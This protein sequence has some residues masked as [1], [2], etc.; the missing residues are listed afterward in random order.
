MFLSR[1]RWIRGFTLIELMVVTAIIAIL[2]AILVPAIQRAQTRA[3]AINC[4]AKG[5]AIASAMRTYASSWDGWTSPDAEHFVKEMGYRLRTDIGYFGEQGYVS[6]TNPGW[7]TNQSSASYGYA[8]KVK[9]FGCPSE[10]NPPSTIHVIRSSYRVVGAM[11]GGNLMGLPGS[12]DETLVVVENNKR[13]PTE[14]ER[15]EKFYIFADLHAQLGFSRV[16]VWKARLQFRP[17]WQ[18]GFG[19]IEVIDQTN[20]NVALNKPVSAT[21]GQWD[22]NWA[23]AHATD[24]KTYGQSPPGSHNQNGHPN[25]PK[26][27]QWDIDLSPGYDPNKIKEV[28]IWVRNDGCCPNQIDGQEIQL[29]DMSDE[30]LWKSTTAQGRPN[31]INVSIQ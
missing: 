1:R 8:R 24:G 29:L 30:I 16:R 6:P 10:A 31:A 25:I 13:H 5:K 21:C 12:A 2:A 28:R 18:G 22:T 20:T 11:A 23:P 27:C 3:L 4:L 17:S 14:G 15:L 26:G 9:D 19:E 7:S